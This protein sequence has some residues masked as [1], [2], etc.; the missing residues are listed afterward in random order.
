MPMT[1][2][3]LS[4]LAAVCVFPL[5]TACGGSD[6]GVKLGDFPAI[7]LAEGD[8]VDLTAPSSK[9]PASF[10]F[11]S[12]DP[13]VAEVSGTKLI[14]KKAGTG[15]ITA[16]QG[17]LG[18]YNPT[19]AST[20]FTVVGYVNQGGLVWMP[21]TVGVRTWENAQAYCTNTT[22]RGLTG[23]RLPT[24]AELAALAGSTALTGQGWPAAD[25]WTSTPGSTAKSH[26]VINLSTKVAAPLADD[27]T[28]SVT[29]VQ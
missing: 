12:S 1:N 24:Q 9:S 29:C 5:L 22:I 26:V 11:S 25:T 4:A 6:D 10:S 14:G 21:P 20:T 3:R 15:T 17:Q 7:T 16:R 18:S 2:I 27:K 8:T 23:W 28:A 13:A 19:S